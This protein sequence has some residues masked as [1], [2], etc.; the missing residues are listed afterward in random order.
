[1]VA[2]AGRGWVLAPCLVRLIEETDRLFPNR[3]TASDGSIGDPA[4]QARVSDHN[5]DG[6]FV[7]AVDITDDDANGC[8]VSVLVHH[9]VASKDSRIKYVIHNRTI[10]RGYAKPGLPAFTPTPYT[11]SNA[12][13]LHAHIS[14]EDVARNDTRTWWPQNQEP[15]KPAPSQPVDLPTE[16]DSMLFQ[17][18]AG[19]VLFLTNGQLLLVVN[20]VDG[21]TAEEQAQ[22]LH[23]QARLP[24]DQ[25]TPVPCSK[26]FWRVLSTAFTVVR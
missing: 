9:L 23:I 4:H 20:A 14:V 26:E 3:S 8:D 15:P 7:D 25:R 21:V 19:S 11:G 12:H 16:D 17:T 22:L 18:P 6:G 2:I 24:V 13:M 10:W 1:M 5:P